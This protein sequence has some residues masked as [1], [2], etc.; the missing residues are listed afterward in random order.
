MRENGD[1]HVLLD[2]REQ[3]EWD[4]G[5][6]ESAVHIVRGFLEF[7]VEEAIPNKSQL[8][9][10]CCAKGGR[11]ALAAATLQKIGYVNVKYLEGGYSGYCEDLK[12]D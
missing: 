3:E 10:I 12:K 1:D 11:S 6:L 4:T 5:H 9:V 2:V 8:I 7:K